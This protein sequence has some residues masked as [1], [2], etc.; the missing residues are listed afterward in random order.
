MLFY[1]DIL[2]EATDYIQEEIIGEARKFDMEEEFPVQHFRYF[3]E[4]LKIFELITSYPDSERAFRTFLEIIRL[5]SIEFSS[6]ASIIFTQAIYAI[7]LL[8]TFGSAEQKE[9]Y[10]D[11]LISCRKLGAFAFSEK[12]ISLDRHQPETIARQTETGWIVIGKKDMVSNATLADVIFVLAQTIDQYGKKALGI[13]VVDRQQEGLQIGPR[14]EKIGVRAMPLAPVILDN[15]HLEPDSLLGGVIKGTE[16]W[17]QTMVKMR[18]VISAQSLGIAEGSFRKG[19]A[20]AKLRRGFGKR[21]IDVEINQLKFAGM[22][23][24]LAACEAYYNEYIRGSMTNER[25]VSMLKVI[26]SDT[27]KEISEEIIRITGSYSFIADNDIERYVHDA[28][29][30]CAYGGETD[31]LKRKIA[32]VWL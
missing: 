22:K 13:F 6:L 27:A 4:E 15:L 24:K 14:E 26:T 16:Q 17:R 31:N 20:Y 18:L 29:I 10:L 28:N 9:A 8:K 12:D 23:T 1:D 25:R 19:L 21:P 5:L 32:E 30:T 2:E 3:A 7:W 11:D